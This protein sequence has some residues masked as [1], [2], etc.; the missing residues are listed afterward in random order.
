MWLRKDRLSN[1]GTAPLYCKIN[2]QGQ[3]TKI[4]TG[5]RVKPSHW[6]SKGDGLITGMSELAESGNL[7]LQNLRAKLYKIYLNLEQQEKIISS[8]IIKEIYEGKRKVNYK[9]I[10]VFDIYLE[11][12]M[13]EGLADSTLR[14]LKNTRKN[15]SHFL[16][17]TNSKNILTDNIE[18]CFANTLSKYLRADC[19]ISHDQSI[20]IINQVK[21]SLEHSFNMGYIESNPL[22][23]FTEKIKNQNPEIKYL[24]DEDMGKI[25]KAEFELEKH[26]RV[27]DL[28]MFQ[29]KTGLAYSD[30]KEFK[31]QEHVK[32]SDKG[33]YIHIRRMK[34]NT[35]CIIP[36]LP[37][38]ITI[39]DKYKDELPIISN[40]KYNEYLKELAEICNVKTVLTTHTARKTYATWLLNK[41]VSEVTVMKA[42]GHTDLKTTIKHYSKILPDKVI[43]DVREALDLM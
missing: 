40:Q 16:E 29:C 36:L 21:A 35:L 25:K 27:R 12:R 43:I 18:K 17:H 37:D 1:D 39:L 6:I 34:T 3:I 8:K 5:L 9:L 4:S 24:D 2:Y 38:S 15:L 13:S 7:I 22:K 31:P 30:L 33:A 32:V 28:F 41:G 42:L 26:E 10:E 11:M 14:K 20:R 23:S 19:N